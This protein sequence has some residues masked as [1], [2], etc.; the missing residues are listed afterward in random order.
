MSGESILFILSVILNAVGLFFQVFF[1]IMYSDLECDYINP[2]ELCNKLNVYII[3]E[4]G[5]HAFLT[6]LFL[7]N[8]YWFVFLLNAPLLAFNAN[9]VLNKTYLLD[10]T[11]IFRT[12]SKHKKESFVKLGFYLFLFF[13]YLYRMIMALIAED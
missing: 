13:F 2:V 5:L 12:L 9:K 7:V 11:E 10:A 8:G 6:A 1:T 3:P 4:A